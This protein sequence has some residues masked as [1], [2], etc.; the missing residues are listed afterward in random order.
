MKGNN[1]INKLSN[2]QD[3]MNENSQNNER[4]EANNDEFV[5]E[6]GII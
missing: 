4:L 5:T 2:S 1:K 3:S 6:N